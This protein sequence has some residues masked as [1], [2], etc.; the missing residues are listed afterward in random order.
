MLPD[1]GREAKQQRGMTK[2]EYAVM[3]VPIALAVMTAVSN[4]STAI[5][6]IFSNVIRL[7]S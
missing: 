7:P 2:V 6:S 4:L 5:K 3:L 1:A